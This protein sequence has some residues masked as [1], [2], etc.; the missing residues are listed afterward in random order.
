MFSSIEE[1]IYL[2]LIQNRKIN[3]VHTS[4]FGIVYIGIISMKTI[5]IKK[6]SLLYKFDYL[7]FLFYLH[8]SIFI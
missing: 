7:M 1:E 3:A 4:I 5:D 6:I 8:T 2:F